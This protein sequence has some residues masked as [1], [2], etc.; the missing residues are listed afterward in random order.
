MSEKG[1]V[2]LLEQ[3]EKAQLST[4]IVAKALGTYANCVR[5]A[6]IH[7]KIE[8]RDKSEAQRASLESGRHEHPTQGR[9]RTEDEKV[10]IGEGVV[11]AWKSS[12]SNYPQG[13]THEQG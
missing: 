6:L 12:K 11:A 4:Y 1:K 10:A 13:T 9:P 5:R 3:Y 8:L 7:H 2:Y